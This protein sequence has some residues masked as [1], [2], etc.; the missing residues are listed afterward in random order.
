MSKTSESA[1]FRRKRKRRRKQNFILILMLYNYILI[2]SKQQRSVCLYRERRNFQNHVD[3]LLQE[4]YFKRYYRCTLS[5]FKILHEKVGPYLDFS[6]KMSWL[7][8]KTK[9]IKVEVKLA[10]ALRYF[11]VG[12]YHDIRTV[13]NFSQPYFFHILWKVVDAINSA[14]K[15]SLPEGNS[16][17]KNTARKFMDR[18]S[19]NIHK[20]VVYCVDGWL[21]PIKCPPIKLR[22]KDKVIRLCPRDYF[23]GHY[24]CHGVNV[25]AA[26]D[27]QCKFTYVQVEDPG[28]VGDA[29]AYEGSPLQKYTKKLPNGIY[30]IGDNAYTCSPHLLVP[31]SGK[32][33]SDQDKDAYNFY[34]SQLRILIEMALGYM[35]S[36]FR[37][38]K[39][40]LEISLLNVAKLIECCF[41]L[42][43]FFIDMKIKDDGA[44]F[45]KNIEK[46][47]E[48]MGLLAEGEEH[49]A[50][51]RTVFNELTVVP[52]E[53]SDL[54]LQHLQRDMILETIKKNN[55]RRPQRNINDNRDRASNN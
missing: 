36:K 3:L 42:H 7:R 13:H 4:G 8:T 26:C 52:D 19:H 47:I 50:Y 24:Q 29:V 40:P 20:G 55:Y 17:I 6:E 11:F 15:I 9:P 2:N 51:M 38:F 43:N 28:G 34:L 14:F 30:G 25:Q 21:A 45:L 54:G 32:Q 12:S 16:E 35:N 48:P 10:S 37:I 44:F 41:K 31:F 23:S 27:Y 39:K 18:S 22:A 5:H 1:I 33:K 53:M 49:H 46:E